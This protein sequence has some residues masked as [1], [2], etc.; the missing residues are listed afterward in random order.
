MIRY[1]KANVEDA[2][3]IAVIE[4][5]TED[6]IYEANEADRDREIAESDLPD[7]FANWQRY[8]AHGYA[9]FGPSV[10]IMSRDGD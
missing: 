5:E 4:A 6:R 9:P 8:T 2:V 3:R 1:F 7:D 10:L